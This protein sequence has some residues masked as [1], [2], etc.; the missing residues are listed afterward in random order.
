[1]SN[2]TAYLGDGQGLGAW[3]STFDHKKIALMFLGWTM[4]LFLFAGIMAGYFKLMAYYGMDVDQATLDRMLTYHGVSMVFMFLIPLIPSVLGFFLLPLQL[5]ARQMAYPTLSRCSLRFHVFGILLMMLS[6]LFAPVGTGWTFSTPYSLI[7]GGA[8]F[9]LALGLFFMALSW[10][11]TGINFLV[12]VHFHRAPGMGFFNLPILTWSLYLTSY[13]LVISG[14]LFAIVIMYLAGAEATGR[15]LFSGLSNPL[16]WQ[17]YFWFITT[18]AAF[19]AVIPAMGV[20]TEVI[21]GISGK[22]V[23]G[24]RTVVGSFIAL[25]ALSFVTWGVH[26]IGMGQDPAVGFTF[27]VLSLLSVVPV[28]LIVYSWL[29]TLNKGAVHCAAPTSFVV[30]FLFNGGIGAML[31]L[32]LVNMSVGSFL[33]ATLFKTAHMHYLMMGG[34]MGAALAGLYFWWPKITG[35]Q[36]NQVVGRLGAFL[37]L[38]GLN[39]AFFPQ[40]IMGSKGLAQGAHI[41]PDSLAT[42]QTV[43]FVGMLVLLLAL[44]VIAVNLISS[45]MSG[46]PAAANPWGAKTL[47]WQT[48]SPPPVGNFETLPDGGEPYLA[49]G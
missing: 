37:Y 33:G 27:A 20:I 25:L 1:M 36:V 39:L 42:L 7:D 44:A 49:D 31:G 5:G 24:Y 15:G 41:V 46:Q 29:A 22:A 28:A 3:F 2:G 47:E 13:V 12:T 48:S 40:I 21:A 6:L 35:R 14:L 19:F 16:D 8:F 45:L 10:V 17:N 43:S 34:V 4:G 32:F 30:G 38:I 9:L 26:L 11:T 18:P 23:S